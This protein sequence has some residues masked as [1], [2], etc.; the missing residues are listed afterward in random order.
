MVFEGKEMMK[1]RGRPG[2]SSQIL[3]YILPRFIPEF[4][5]SSAWGETT[6]L[7]EELVDRWYDMWMREGQRAAELDRLRQYEAGDLE[8]VVAAV[9]APVLI[10]WG[11]ANPQAKVEQAP[12]FI[13]LLSG[14]ESV[15]LKIYPGVGHMAVQEAGDITGVDV[16]AFLDGT[17]DLPDQK[18]DTLESI[19]KN[20]ILN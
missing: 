15:Q 13:E 11:E 3:A 20:E 6:E 16:R 8:S 7:P 1:Q 4:M 19:S 10:L 5:L 18:H 14:A 9:R 12:E 2:K 17:L